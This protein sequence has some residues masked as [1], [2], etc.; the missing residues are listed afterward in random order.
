LAWIKHIYGE[1]EKRISNIEHR[2]QNFEEEK[3]SGFP[4]C[5]GNDDV[6]ALLR[7]RRED[8]EYRTGN[9]DVE[10]LLRWRRV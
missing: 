7:W 2:T 4:A 9:D 10:A 8:I 5:A 1:R 3:R 6:G